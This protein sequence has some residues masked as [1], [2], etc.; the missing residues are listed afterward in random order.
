MRPSGATSVQAVIS[1]ENEKGRKL[2]L[3]Q[4][5]FMQRFLNTCEDGA[6]R[7]TA[8]L[9]AV[10]NGLVFNLDDPVLRL[11][12]EIPTFQTIH[13][14]SSHEQCE[15]AYEFSKRLTR[16]AQKH[17]R[18]M[19]QCIQKVRC[20]GSLLRRQ[21]LA[22][23]NHC[24]QNIFSF[25]GRQ[26]FLPFGKETETMRKF[27]VEASFVFSEIEAPSVFQ[28]VM[29]T[30][31]AAVIDPTMAS[32]HV[33]HKVAETLAE[34]PQVP[35]RHM[36]E[37]LHLL[38]YNRHSDAFFC[39]LE[40]GLSLQTCRTALQE[41]G[42]HWR[43]ACGAWLFVHPW[44]YAEAAMPVLRSCTVELRPYHVI[45]SES[46]E[47]AVESSFSELPYRQRPRPKQEQWIGSADLESPEMR[48]ETEALFNMIWIED[49]TFLSVVPLRHPAQT[50][51]QSTTEA[52]NG[53]NPRRVVIPS[54][55]D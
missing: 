32:L 53:L 1:K 26:S 14:P 22:D 50:V 37:N 5:E 35:H 21:K 55:L 7:L 40:E 41:A 13:D 25:L 2:F 36:T 43:L 15:E 17:A 16:F 4:R 28:E 38:T 48:D 42:F 10:E 29:H 45:V 33:Q 27:K 12:G 8:L 34:L 11:D 54:S 51:N 46:L 30:D 24:V 39:A 44:Q 19:V 47:Y 23:R 6:K 18:M 20:V 3:Q 52:H 31:K 49:K 9:P